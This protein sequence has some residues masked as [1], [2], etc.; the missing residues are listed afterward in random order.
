MKL[1][2]KKKNCIYVQ[3]V[4]FRNT[5]KDSDQFSD[6]SENVTADGTLVIDRVAKKHEGFYMCEANNDVGSPIVSVVR[7]NVQGK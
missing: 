6:V 7:F 2:D 1:N 3:P 5:G 4:T